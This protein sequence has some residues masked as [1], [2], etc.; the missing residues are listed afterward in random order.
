M[1]VSNAI[2]NLQNNKSAG[3]DGM[4]RTRGIIP[5]GDGSLKSKEVIMRPVQHIRMRKGY[6]NRKET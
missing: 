5:P 6:H 3:V 1:Q 2:N 4:C